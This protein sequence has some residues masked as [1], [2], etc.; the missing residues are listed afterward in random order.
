MMFSLLTQMGFEL[1]VVV[2]LTPGALAVG[3]TATLT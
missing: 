3:A 2:A 1:Y